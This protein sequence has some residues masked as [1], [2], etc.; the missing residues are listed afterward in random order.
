ADAFRG[1]W[2]HTGDLATIDD[3]GWV[4]IVDRKKDMIVTGGEN[5]YSVE[6]ENALY[7]HPLVLECAAYG[8]PSAEWGETVCA[9]VVL[10]GDG[11]ADAEALR[12]HCRE[13]LAGYK[14]PRRVE[15]L[16]ELPKTG[17]GKIAKRLL[18][19][20]AEAAGATG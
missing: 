3:E 8:V 16:D 7:D 14:V 6:V 10:R 15:V 11:D 4:D 20:R 18:R 17:S 1:G 5:V 2:F 13:R 9:A 19:E 12:A